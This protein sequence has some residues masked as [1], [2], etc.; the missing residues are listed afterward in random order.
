MDSVS[1]EKLIYSGLC[2]WTPN[3]PIPM[4]PRLN[5]SGKLLTT[6]VLLATFFWPTTNPDKAY[7]QII[8]GIVKGT[9]S[10]ETIP[11]NEFFEIS[12]TV[13]YLSGDGLTAETL[14]PK[15]SEQMLLDQIDYTF[16]PRVLPIL[17]GEKMSFHNSDDELHNIHTYSKGRRRNRNFNRAQRPGSTFTGTFARPDSILVLCDIHSQMIAHILILE[18]GFF[19][20]ASTT[21]TYAIN[22][23]PPGQYDLTVWNEW[24]G[25]VKT[26]IEITDGQ[27]ISVDVTFPNTP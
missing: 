3:I 16:V 27:T 4:I 14:D 1:I 21:G 19:T 10:F 24:F 18:N 5:I 7:S 25:E 11:D 15:A 26:T 22:D 8:N 13:I 2:K 20:K 17:A 12:E 6:V 23:V 9:V